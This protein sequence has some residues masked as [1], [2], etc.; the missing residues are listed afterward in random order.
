MT[1]KRSVGRRHDPAVPCTRGSAEMGRTNGRRML[2]VAIALGVW[3]FAGAAAA[4]PQGTK[5]ESWPDV[6]A[7]ANVQVTIE[8]VNNCEWDEPVTISGDLSQFPLPPTP[9]PQKTVTAASRQTSSHGYPFVLAA[10]EGPLTILILAEHRESEH[11]DD[12]CYAA[13]ASLSI[14]TRIVKPDPKASA[15]GRAMVLP[16]TVL[17][18]VLKQGITI[19]TISAMPPPENP[20]PRVGDPSGGGGTVPT[21]GGGS[22]GSGSGGG[23]TAGGG[24][25]GTGSTG[26]GGTGGGAGGT[27]PPPPPKAPSPP[28]FDPA[29]KMTDLPKGAGF[30][31]QARLENTCS[32]D[33]PV[34]IRSWFGGQ[35]QVDDT[36]IVQAKD[37]LT[38]PIRGEITGDSGAW[39][40]EIA[41]EQAV[42]PDGTKTCLK[43]TQV[44]SI[45]A[46]EA[47][48]GQGTGIPARLAR[49]LVT[50]TL[51]ETSAPAPATAPSRT[52][53]P[54]EE[55]EEEG[56]EPS[57]TDGQGGVVNPEF[58]T[59][60]LNPAAQ[61]IFTEG[62]TIAVPHGGLRGRLERFFRRLAPQP[63]HA[64]RQR[65]PF[66]SPAPVVRLAVVATGA[67]TG[68]VF[69]VSMVDGAGRD[70]RVKL[71]DGI[72]LQ[73][74]VGSVPKTVARAPRV[75]ALSGYCLDF[76]KA[77][78]S[79]GTL[80]QIA[81]R[82]IQQKFRPYR[83]V[84]RAARKLQQMNLLH[85]DS[86]PAQYLDAIKQWSLWTR[87]EKWDL[88]QF[89]AKFVERTRKNVEAVKGK[90][91]KAIEELVRQRVPN[92]WNDIQA[93]LAEA[94]ALAKRGD[95]R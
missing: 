17:R 70:V 56:D 38:L 44:R 66:P 59:G 3:S 9:L 78:P 94:D 5:E 32:W 12:S 26:G 7:N 86:D 73:P 83:R 76:V 67:S 22:S 65:G 19:P 13:S 30:Q 33:R 91:T 2:V 46:T 48:G 20:P 29:T 28:P 87:I 50:L 60:P 45:G 64:S 90:W 39:Q 63:M 95:E 24:G 18:I 58:V 6:T 75:G 1:F 92:R 25:G 31:L 74:V 77:T 61:L 8:V 54:E 79:P 15:I 35:V 84:L 80:Y 42:S 81:D 37:T 62:A 53:P 10:R 69:T 71:P 34:T 55:E 11:G 82:A 41:H 23:G 21:T 47:G 36:V 89:T 27:T 72:V 43:T 14:E 4:Q 16:R 68:S 88:D 51:S 93:V 85:P 40:L 52:A 49:T 57:G